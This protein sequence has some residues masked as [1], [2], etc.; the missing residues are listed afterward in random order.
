MLFKPGVSTLLKLGFQLSDPFHQI[1]DLRPRLVVGQR[2]KATVCSRFQILPGEVKRLSLVN[3]PAKLSSL[4]KGIC[5]IKLIGES[6]P[7]PICGIPLI[8]PLTGELI[9]AFPAP[10]PGFEHRFYPGGGKQVIPNRLVNPDQAYF[11][12]KAG[13]RI[14]IAYHN[15]KCQSGFNVRVALAAF[16]AQRANEINELK[17][18]RGQRRGLSSLNS[19]LAY[20]LIVFI[21]RTNASKALR[22]LAPS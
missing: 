13:W 2:E 20:A 8:F 7:T 3:K 4:V 21:W 1:V 15:E 12:R 17:E 10:A 14:S 9:I 5:V 18:I 19:F 6:F 16:E 11:G 22:Q